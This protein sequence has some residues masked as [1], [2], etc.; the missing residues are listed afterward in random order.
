MSNI[1]INK[2]M[3]DIMQ[4]ENLKLQ[5]GSEI[6]IEN[7]HIRVLEDLKRRNRDNG[8]VIAGEY[9]GGKYTYDE[10]FKMINDYKKA[11]LSLDGNNS[12]SITVSSPAVIVFC[13]CLLWSN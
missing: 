4:Q 3:L 1:N 2:N 11:F 7:P 12:H 5:S 13:Q 6:I 8:S 10:T 9:F